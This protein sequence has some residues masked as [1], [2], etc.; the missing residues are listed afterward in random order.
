[1]CLLCKHKIKKRSAIM[2]AWRAYASLQDH[3]GIFKMIVVYLIVHS[4]GFN[5]AFHLFQFISIYSFKHQT[6]MHWKK[7]TANVSQQP[8]N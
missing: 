8:D 6:N 3:T 5:F 2:E 1:M 4:K 7:Y